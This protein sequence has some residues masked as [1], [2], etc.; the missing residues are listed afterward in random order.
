VERPRPWA[1]LIVL[2][3]GTF[4]ILLDTTIV[5]VAL[6]SLVTSLHASLDQA[7]WVVNGY[8]LV[9]CALL[10]VASRLGDSSAAGGSSW[11]GWPSSR[12]PRRC[13]GRRRTRRS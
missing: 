13:A 4:A 7:L 8:L 12:W 2:C 1:I 10:I 3:L 6:P 11:P 5:N 9:F